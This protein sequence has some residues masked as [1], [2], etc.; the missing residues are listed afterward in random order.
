MNS[1]HHIT[2]A[3]SN[4]ELRDKIVS[5]LQERGMRRTPALV[6]LIGEMVAHTQPASLH[7]WS[8]RPGLS[9]H[10]PATIYRI[11]MKLEHAKV[12]RRVNISERCSYFQII[13][14]DAQPDYL[15][16]TDCGDLQT[17]ETP[18]ELRAME[19]R[20]IVQAGWQG[21]RH[22]LEFFGLCPHC[23]QKDNAQQFVIAN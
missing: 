18:P 11:M 20:F 10:D 12:V 19:E 6:N 9:E 7:D 3:D 5:G 4:A 14:S 8:K 16:C 1:R 17:V 13:L 15:V 21:V 23:A 22:E 2:M